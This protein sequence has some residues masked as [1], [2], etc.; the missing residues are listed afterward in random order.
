MSS[1]GTPRQASHSRTDV[2]SLDLF[3]QAATAILG[4]AFVWEQAK[5]EYTP[6][7]NDDS[8]V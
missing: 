4:Q 7:R 6:Q 3:A 1:I 5:D 2:N 8:G